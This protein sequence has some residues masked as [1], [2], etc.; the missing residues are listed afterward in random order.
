MAALHPS[1][2]F[3]SQCVSAFVAICLCF[4]LML[5]L[6]TNEIPSEIQITTPSYILPSV[7]LQKETEPVG[8]RTE[9]QKVLPLQPPPGPRPGQLNRAARVEFRAERPTF[10][11][12]AEII[13]LADLQL[14]LE[15]PISELIPLNIV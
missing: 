11:S 13:G 9:H 7:T 2:K 5:F 6:I 12:I 10:G 15:T 1:I 14:K 4:Y 8:T 3:L